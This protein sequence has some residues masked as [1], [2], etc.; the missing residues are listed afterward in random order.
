M[1]ARTVV[2]AVGCRSKP[3]RA[4]ASHTDPLQLA[5]V[6]REELWQAQPSRGGLLGVGRVRVRECAF[7]STQAMPC[8]CDAS[9]VKKVS[10]LGSTARLWMAGWQV[11]LCNHTM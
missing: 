8:S 4:R 10:W 2:G 11:M 7:T 1:L 5:V 9:T 6:L 3:G